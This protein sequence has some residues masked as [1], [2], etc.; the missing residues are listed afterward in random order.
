MAVTSR[1]LGAS[2]DGLGK[3]EQ[4]L[5]AVHMALRKFVHYTQDGTKVVVHVPLGGLPLVV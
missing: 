4:Y 5:V 1:E 3:A 2:L